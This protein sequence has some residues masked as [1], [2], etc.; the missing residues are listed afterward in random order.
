MADHPPGQ[1]LKPEERFV[2]PAC[3]KGNEWRALL[4][5]SSAGTVECCS[6]HGTRYAGGSLSVSEIVKKNIEL[7][8]QSRTFLDGSRRSV[9]TFGSALIGYGEYRPGWRWSKHAGAQTGR[10]SEVHLGVILSGQLVVRG[11]DGVEML[12]GPGEAFEAQPGHDAW[13]V[14][15]AACVA[16]D[17][18][19]SS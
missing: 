10:T 17:F 5:Q 8:G 9:V 19:A 4:D 16:L 6:L 1:R 12:A 15:E 13:V 11:A 3:L 7:D 2:A 14:G 18:D